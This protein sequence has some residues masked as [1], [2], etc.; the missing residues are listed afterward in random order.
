MNTAT[1]TSGYRGV[2][3]SHKDEP[4]PPPLVRKRPHVLEPGMVV[5]NTS[6][7]EKWTIEEVKGF[8]C[9]AYQGRRLDAENYKR[10]A[11]PCD[12]MLPWIDV[13]TVRGEAVVSV[14]RELSPVEL[15]QR[16]AEKA[17]RKE[18]RAAN[19][20][21]RATAPRKELDD[22]AKKLLEPKNLDELWKLAF[23][24]GL[25]KDL[26]KKLEH[27][28]PGLQRM[29]IGNRLRNMAKKAGQK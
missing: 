24:M 8:W 11:F 3:L 6:S 29:N 2:F 25:P 22:I 15:A 10:Q 23:K 9:W 19:R 12:V 26:R 16:A 21:A 20:A 13:K 27:L 28:N 7:G 18:Q 17:E 4:P 1:K 14:R 5:E